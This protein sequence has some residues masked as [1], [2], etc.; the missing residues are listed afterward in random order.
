LCDDTINLFAYPHLDDDLCVRVRL[1]PLLTLT[2]TMTFA[3]GYDYPLCLPP[4]GRWTLCEGTIILFAY[5]HL[6]D[7]QSSP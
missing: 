1:S 3:W 2:W 5:P 4:L 7:D 6:D